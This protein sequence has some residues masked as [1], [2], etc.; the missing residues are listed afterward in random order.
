MG[1]RDAWVGLGRRPHAGRLESVGLG[2]ARIANEGCAQVLASMR[3]YARSCEAIRN[4]IVLRATDGAEL[5]GGGPQPLMV[6][7]LPKQIALA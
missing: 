3:K 7:I 5:S 6:P 2:F 4:A 1:V